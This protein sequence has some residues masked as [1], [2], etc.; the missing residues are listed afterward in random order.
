MMGPVTVRGDEEAFVTGIDLCDQP[1]SC[2]PTY[3]LSAN[4]LKR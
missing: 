1:K 3:F 4:N 2:S